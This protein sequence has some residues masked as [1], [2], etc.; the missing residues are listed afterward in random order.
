MQNIY[1]DAIPVAQ[2]QTAVQLVAQCKSRAWWEE[3]CREIVQSNN[4]TT[5]TLAQQLS[6]FNVK[7]GNISPPNS[8]FNKKAQLSLTKPRDACEN[9]ARFT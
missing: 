1:T 4:K 9:F 8:V 7:Q 6:Q 3:E 2:Q 5:S